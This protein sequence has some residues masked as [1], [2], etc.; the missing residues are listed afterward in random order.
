MPIRVKDTI[1]KSAIETL[2]VKTKASESSMLTGT[3]LTKNVVSTSNSNIYY[4]PGFYIR[5][6][7]SIL[8]H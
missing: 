6:L 1:V 5:N 7:L 8:K 4:E 3:I 2:P